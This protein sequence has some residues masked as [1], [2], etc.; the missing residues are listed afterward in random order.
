MVLYEENNICPTCGQE[1]PQPEIS[2]P[3]T[4]RKRTRRI[5]TE[6]SSLRATKELTRSIK[7]DF[8]K[9]SY[10]QEELM[11]IF[12][13]KVSQI[14]KIKL[15]VRG[16]RKRYMLEDVLKYIRSGQKKLL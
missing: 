10:N 7:K 3:I 4:A 11:F 8:Y 15:T 1:M 16:N 6:K 5:T 13:F 2:S 14:N 9:N 12:N